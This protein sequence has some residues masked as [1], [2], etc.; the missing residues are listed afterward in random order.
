M[1]RLTFTAVLLLGLLGWSSCDDYQLVNTKSE[2]SKVVNLKT[3]NCEIVS[4]D[5]LRKLREQAEIGKNVGRYQMREQGYR[6]WR[7]DSATGRT[8]LL[9]SSESDWKKLDTLNQSCELAG[10]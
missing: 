3:C 5:D 4:K 7:F 6:T 10:N 9:L 2:E 1:R 8:C